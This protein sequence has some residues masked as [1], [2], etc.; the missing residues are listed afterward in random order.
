MARALAL[1]AL[2]VALAACAGTPAPKVT[3]IPLTPYTK[4]QQAQIA[5]ALETASP[6]LVG[7]ALDWERM[8]DAD[9]ACL[10]AQP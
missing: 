6:L 10:A 8:R 3:C 1:M 5:D 2:C 4:D 7:V 9:R